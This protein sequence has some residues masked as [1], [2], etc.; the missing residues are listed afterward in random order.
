MTDAARPLPPAP[1][2]KAPGAP[3][4]RTR[5]EPLLKELEVAELLHISVI[6]LRKWRWLGDGP[7]FL[8]LGHNVRYRESEVER[9]LYGR[10]RTSTSDPGPSEDPR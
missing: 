10:R 5:L 3:A 2:P 7:P 6:T 9:W 4:R 1:E 8:K